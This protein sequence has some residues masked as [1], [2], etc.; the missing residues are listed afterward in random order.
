M[1]LRCRDRVLSLERTAVMGVLNVTPDSFSDGGLWLDPRAA[2]EHGLEMAAEGATIIDVGG[3]STRPGASPVPEEEELRRIIP[4]VERLAT[5]SDVA[6]SVDT[7]KPNVARRAVDAGARIINDTAGELADPGMDSVAADT[8]A[9]IAVMHSRGNPATMRS[10]AQYDDVV[11][12]V[13]SFLRRRAGELEAAG[14]L[15]EA[16]AVD[17]GFGFAKNPHHNLVLLSRIRE[18]IDIGYPL[19]VGTSRKSFIGA[20]LD[21]P[22]SE[23][24]EGTAAT[25]AWAVA[26]GAQMVRVHDVKEMVRIVAMTEAIRDV[27]IG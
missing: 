1:K 19:L 14:V 7:R 23:R 8:G 21:L 5:E 20:L 25:V 10:L 18:L 12:E 26:A 22:E 3:E 9:A 15:R 17:P 13:A 27:R 4:V 11:A 16:I 6:V 2:V 24:L